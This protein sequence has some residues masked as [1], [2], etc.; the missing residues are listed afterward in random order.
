MP[1]LEGK[2]GFTRTSTRILAST[3]SSSHD[4][5]LGMLPALVKAEDYMKKIPI[6]IALILALA[7]PAFA[8]EPVHRGV[9]FQIGAGPS[10]PSY[11]PEVEYFL[12]YLESE[13]GMDRV[14]VAVDLA[15]GFPV[16]DTS[17]LML[18][19][20]GSGDRFDYLGEYFQLNLYLYSIG[21]RHYPS[22]TGFYAEAGL[23]SSLLVGKSSDMPTEESDFG[24]GFGLALG[25][26]FN[27]APRGL[28]LTLEA[29]YNWLTI[30]GEDCGGL[31][32]LLSLCWK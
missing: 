23:G 5:G 19:M 11:P 28:G 13:P 15:L 32:I 26:D 18:R 10:F 8:Q 31:M 12:D 30:E 9:L 27:T 1:E 16:M 20:D 17:Y 25:Y 21:L 2:A 24:S 4:P 3:W 7:V 6:I 29:K 22:G 14:Q